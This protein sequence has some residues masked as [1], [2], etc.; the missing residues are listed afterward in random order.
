MAKYPDIAAGRPV[1]AALLRSMLPEIVYK[2]TIDT[3]TNNTLA[4][5]TELFVTAEANASYMVE[6][7]LEPAAVTAEGFKTDWVVPAGSSGFKGVLGPSSTASNSNADLITMRAGVH[8]FVT[9]VPY[10]G[11]RNNA[12][13]AFSVRESGVVTTAG[14]AGTIGIRW[15]QNTTGA[16]GAKLLSGSYMKVYR[17]A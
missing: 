8:A 1:T 12:N 2:A 4:L 3:R 10:A 7:V 15:A 9:A 17:V 6:F 5:D 16:T 11:V 13:A 14:T